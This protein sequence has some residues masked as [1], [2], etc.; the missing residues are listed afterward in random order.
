M[1]HEALVAEGNRL[2]DVLITI[3]RM[4]RDPETIE[5]QLVVIRANGKTKTDRLDAITEAMDADCVCGHAKTIHAARGGTC[6]FT[7][8]AGAHPMVCPCKEWE[9]E[10]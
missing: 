8:P 2:S 4:L 3:S 7:Y 5:E 10:L 1:N 6:M 9:V